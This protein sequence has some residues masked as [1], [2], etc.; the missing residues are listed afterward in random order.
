M[1]KWKIKLVWIFPFDTIDGIKY[2]AELQNSFIFFF[3]EFFCFSI[4]ACK[5][6]SQCTQSEMFEM[7]SV[8]FTHHSSTGSILFPR[9]VFFIRLH[10]TFKNKQ[11][12]T[13]GC[14]YSFK[15]FYFD[16]KRFNH[17]N[18]WVWHSACNLVFTHEFLLYFVNNVE[19]KFETMVKFLQITL[20]IRLRV[21]IA[22]LWIRL[23]CN[24]LAIYM[25]WLALY[26]VLN[27]HQ[28]ECCFV[29]KETKSFHCSDI[30]AIFLEE[31]YSTS[32]YV[33]S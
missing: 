18:S 14:S 28:Q 32:F 6:I 31:K 21:F 5:F 4:Y 16:I 8:Y 19:K 11:T 12:Y 13:H 30:H 25:D 17:S 29:R 23:R 26:M 24:T 2:I 33:P 3:P 20:K 15:Y 7:M 9:R 22:F 27:S 1:S 10:F